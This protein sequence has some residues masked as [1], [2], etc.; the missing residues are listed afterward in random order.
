MTVLINDIIKISELESGRR[1][2]A[3]EK[4]NLK[5]LAS[6]IGEGLL[7]IAK[8]KCITIEVAGDDAVISAQRED[9][10][11]IIGNL[12]DNA[13][14]YNV[15]GGSVKVLCKQ[16]RDGISITVADTGIGI[17]PRHHGRI[18]ERFYCV[19]KGRSRTIGGTGLGLSIVKHAAARWGGEILF[20][21][22]EGEGTTITVVFKNRPAAI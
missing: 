9:M 4:V 15:R 16:M 8:E 12:M 20:E 5:K 1:P 17:A 6:E 18:F 3:T 13:V 19:D 7:P 21:S 2:E 10:R 22:A 11:Q 14:K